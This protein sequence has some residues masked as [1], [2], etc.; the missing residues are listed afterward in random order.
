MISKSYIRQLKKMHN[1]AR[2]P[3]G[4]GGAMKNLGEVEY[5]L[6][7]W[8]P[9]SL[10]DYGCGKGVI[11]SYLRE[12]YPN[13][14]IDGYDPAV[15][16]FSEIPKNKYYDCVFCVD[17]LEHIEPNYLHDVLHHIDSLAK[18]YIWLRI[19]TMPARKF[20]ADGRNAHLLLHDQDWWSEILQH[21]INGLQIYNNLNRKG[22]LDVAI[23][24]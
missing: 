3:R 23:E 19:D 13:T 20:L 14:K 5:Y 22:K 15:D 21:N 10:L 16:M 12:N 24:K 7:K 6:K 8:Q 1:S 9:H 17:V 2:R 11:T 4:F 18:N